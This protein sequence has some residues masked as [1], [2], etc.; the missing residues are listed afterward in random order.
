M[1]ALNFPASPTDL[2]IY[3]VTAQQG[4]G[5][6]QWRATTGTWEALPF[7]M[8]VRQ[9][10]YNNYNWPNA[11]GSTDQQLE[12]DGAGNLFWATGTGAQFRLLGLLEP[13]DGFNVAFTL[14]DL[15]TANP[16]SPS[17]STNIAVFLGGVPQIP[18][19]A[20]SVSTN[21]ITFTEAP[22]LGATFYAISAAPN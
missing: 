18:L 20:Y 15:G 19:A 17:P 7:F 11:D 9:G 16:Y 22:L 3:P 21:T 1:A 6:W 10:D 8:R 5:Q 14:V 13:F 12:T 2:Q 4:I